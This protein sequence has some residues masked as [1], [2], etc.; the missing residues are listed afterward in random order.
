MKKKLAK[1][2]ADLALAAAKSAAG[3]ASEWLIYQPKEPQKLI[4]IL[5]R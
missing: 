2:A 5:K 1:M 4:E 3:T